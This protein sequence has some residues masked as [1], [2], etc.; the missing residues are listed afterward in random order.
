MIFST[1]KEHVQDL[2]HWFEALIHNGLNVALLKC[3]SFHGKVVYMGMKFHFSQDGKPCYTYTAL[4]PF[5]HTTFL[6]ARLG[7]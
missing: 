4:A 1:V 3:Q 5:P 2:K 7:H 6:S